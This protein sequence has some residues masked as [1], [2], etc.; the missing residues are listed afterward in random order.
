MKKIRQMNVQ[1]DICHSQLHPLIEG[2]FA[3]NPKNE[4]VVTNRTS[5]NGAAEAM[6]RRYHPPKR[7][8]VLS[9]L[10]FI[11]GEYFSF[12]NVINID[13]TILQNPGLGKVQMFLS[14]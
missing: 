13:D 12:K 14:S 5:A 4:R 9:I 10:P 8:I 1:I 3:F 2:L 11:K 6:R 7:F